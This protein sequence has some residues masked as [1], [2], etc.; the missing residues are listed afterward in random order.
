MPTTRKQKSKARK[1]RGAEMLSVLENIE[2][3]LGT[4]LFERE[5]SEFSK[6]VR[7]LENLSYHALVNIESNS[8]SNSREN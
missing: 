1:S 8:H 7:R 6:S 3:M 4:N 5:E 2:I